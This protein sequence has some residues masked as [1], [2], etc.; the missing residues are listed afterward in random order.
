[1]GRLPSSQD[2]VQNEKTGV[3]R[4]QRGHWSKGTVLLSAMLLQ[5][6]GPRACEAAP[7][8]GRR[9]REGS[10]HCGVPG[11]PTYLHERVNEKPAEPATGGR[12]AEKAARAPSA[13][14]ARG[15]HASERSP[16]SPRPCVPTRWRGRCTGRCS[17][18]RKPG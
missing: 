9:G 6:R 15:R 12:A 5:L 13:P 16:T 8:A 1:M 3:S 18:L 4:W 2:T 11:T 17:L 7:P 14:E 10:V